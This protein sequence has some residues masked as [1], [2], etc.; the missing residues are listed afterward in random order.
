MGFDEFEKMMLSNK[1]GLNNLLNDNSGS[2]NEDESGGE[3][4]LFQKDN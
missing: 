2:E 1:K 3:L 4:D